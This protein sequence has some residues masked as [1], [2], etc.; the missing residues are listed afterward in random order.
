MWL[1]GMVVGLILAG[2]VLMNTGHGSHSHEGAAPQGQAATA[3]D[4]APAESE[5]DGAPAESKPDDAPDAPAPENAPQ[6]EPGHH[7][8]KGC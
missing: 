8:W 3:P 2:H 5:P 1:I 6:P 4:G 7:H